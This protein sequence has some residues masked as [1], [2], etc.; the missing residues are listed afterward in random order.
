MPKLESEKN[1]F[2]VRIRESTQSTGTLTIFCCVRNSMP[3]NVNFCAGIKSD[4]FRF[5]MKPRNLDFVP[6]EGNRLWEIFVGCESN[7][8]S[9]NR[10]GRKQGYGML[11]QVHFY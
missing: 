8:S 5:G 9:A 3:I 10:L 4:F 1:S 7:L 6:L 11:T 2:I